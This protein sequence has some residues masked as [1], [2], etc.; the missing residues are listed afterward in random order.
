M[1]HLVLALV[2]LANTLAM[3]SLLHR[4]HRDVTQL[5]VL[6]MAPN[7]F[8][9]QYQGCTHMMKEELEDLNHTEF[10]NNNIYSK[11][12]TLATEEWQ[13]RRSRVSLPRALRPEHAITLLAYTQQSDLYSNFNKAVR[14]AGSSKEEYLHSFSFKVLHFLLTE[15]LSILWDTQPQLPRCHQVYRGVK[16]IQFTTRR[17][18]HI[19]FGSFTSTSFREKRAADFGR[20]TFFSVMTCY[21]VPVGDF[22]FYPD[23]E[24]VLIPPFEIFEVTN[25]TSHHGN[26]TVIHLHSEDTSSTHNCVYVKEKRC[27]TRRCV[28][29]AGRSIL[30]DPSHLWVL[31]LP[32]MVLASTQGP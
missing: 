26:R 14:V 13:S 6:D 12:W 22:S 23:E 18:Q 11:A 27:K 17:Q 29:S 16:G 30:G 28:F 9:D 31:L 21:G 3:G 8:D 19:R 32:A 5:L 24:E 25:V 7:S 2:L 4:Q 1:E 15:A 10:T 20:N